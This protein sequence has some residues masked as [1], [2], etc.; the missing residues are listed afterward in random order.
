MGLI[1]RDFDSVAVAHL[2]NKTIVEDGW[3]V[4]TADRSK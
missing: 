4:Q 3:V 2:N 1:I